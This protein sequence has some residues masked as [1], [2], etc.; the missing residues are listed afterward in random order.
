[1][2]KIAISFEYKY[3]CDDYE[4]D[5][6]TYPKRKYFK[7]SKGK[8]RKK[9]I[10][11]I[12]KSVNKFSKEHY[13][14]CLDTFD[15]YQPNDPEY[16][17]MLYCYRWA[18]HGDITAKYDFITQYWDFGRDINDGKVWIQVENWK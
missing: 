14:Y 3:D 5:P 18:R 4:A 17:K 2:E 15:V 12:W 13:D 7:I 6:K 1:M 10:N 16:I 9:E 8:N 11:A